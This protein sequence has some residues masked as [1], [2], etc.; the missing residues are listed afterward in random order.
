MRDPL[1]VYQRWRGELDR[2]SL[3]TIARALRQRYQHDE[4]AALR[5]WLL[6][7]H[8]EDARA[9]VQGW[10]RRRAAAFEAIA[11]IE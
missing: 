5:E 3:D 10:D 7:N 6:L 2:A 1:G 9:A 11:E 8:D 4:C